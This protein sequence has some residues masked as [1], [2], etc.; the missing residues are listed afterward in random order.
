MVSTQ[1]RD[2]AA[3]DIDLERR[4]VSALHR[5]ARPGL[6]E[7]YESLMPSWL[8]VKPALRRLLMLRTHQWIAERVLAP[9]RRHGPPPAED[10]RPDGALV[11][12][13]VALLP[14]GQAGEWRSWIR[15]VAVEMKRALRWPAE[16]RNEAWA[17][18][19]FLI[20]YSGPA[21]HIPSGAGHPAPRE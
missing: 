7:W 11:R 2:P 16:Q 12:S 5:A 21:G 10:L 9:A 20:P 8:E 17:H 3:S 14:P 18:W 6:E 1:V 15:L 13:L 19:L 4:V